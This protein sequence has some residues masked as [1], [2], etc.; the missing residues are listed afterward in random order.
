MLRRLGLNKSVH[1]KQLYI[2]L[3]CC[4]N[5]SSQIRAWAVRCQL[6]SLPTKDEFTTFQ[7]WKCTV[8]IYTIWE[9]STTCRQT[10]A[11]FPDTH[12]SFDLDRHEQISQ[13]LRPIA[14]FQPYF[15]HTLR[16]LHT[17]SAIRR[18]GHTLSSLAAST[19]A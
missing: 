4:L 12:A 13:P 9:W 5:W 11:S 19:Q 18:P 3:R 16:I 10:S 6:D 8:W 14:V 1:G 15:L 17:T 7:V 2:I